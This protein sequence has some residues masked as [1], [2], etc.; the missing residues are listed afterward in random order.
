MIFPQKSFP[1]YHA[2]GYLKIVRIDMI[3]ILKK[4]YILYGSKRLRYVNK[5]V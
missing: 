1:L 2:T 3:E 4:M 5:K